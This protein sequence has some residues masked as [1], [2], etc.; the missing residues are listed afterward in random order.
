MVVPP[1]PDPLPGGERGFC[2]WPTSGDLRLLPVHRLP[3]NGHAQVPPCPLLGWLH[4]VEDRRPRGRCQGAGSWGTGNRGQGTGRKREGSGIR[5]QESGGRGQD[6][7]VRGWGLERGVG[8]RDWEA[9]PRRLASDALR[10]LPTHDSLTPDPW[11]PTPDF[12][13]P[14]PNPNPWPPTPDFRPL[15]PVTCALSPLLAAQKCPPEARRGTSACLAT[16]R[17]HHHGKYRDVTYLGVTG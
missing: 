11:P 15:S 17:G 6:E 10:W 12:R 7:G 9:R 8:V 4:A 13:P 3:S 1:H 2:L 16:F 14:I 5:G